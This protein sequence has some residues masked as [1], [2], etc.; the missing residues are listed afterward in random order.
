MCSCSRVVMA[1]TIDFKICKH[2]AADC[3]LGLPPKSDCVY[4][5]C[6]CEE[7]V[8]FLCQRAL[9][10]KQSHPSCAWSFFAVFISNPTESV[11]LWKQQSS[12]AP[13]NMTVWDYHVILVA[14]NSQ[15][16]ASLVFDLD[17]TLDFPCSASCYLDE[18]IR[19]HCKIKP[20]YQRFFRVVPGYEF[21]SH[22]SS[23]RHH[24]RRADGSWL[25]EPP[26]YPPIKGKE[27]SSDHNLP[28]FISMKKGEG[29]GTVMD[30]EEFAEFLVGH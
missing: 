23:D 13:A 7:N 8:W 16:H 30:V 1:S 25:A 10:H 27:A 14:K 3:M 24:M 18:A 21:V 29:P 4:T 2:S 5:S 26:P 20:R 28:E 11:V 19:I 6:Y 12:S 15:T 22:F 9:T 17:T